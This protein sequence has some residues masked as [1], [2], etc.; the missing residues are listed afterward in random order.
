MGK[1]FTT[2]TN[3]LLI[4]STVFILST[5]HRLSYDIGSRRLSKRFLGDLSEYLGHSKVLY[6]TKWLTEK[7]I[8]I[9]EED[10]IRE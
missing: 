10:R 4:V 5:I 3:P 7:K 2:R 8:L 9:R 1:T 6:T